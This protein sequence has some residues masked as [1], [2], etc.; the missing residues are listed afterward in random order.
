MP[1]IDVHTGE[2]LTI[3]FPPHY[4]RQADGTGKLSVDSTSPPPISPDGSESLAFS[5]RGRIPP[6]RKAWNFLPDLIAN[7]P[8]EDGD[9]GSPY[10]FETRK[11]L[12]PLHILQPD[13]V[14]FKVTGNV[15]EW[16]GWKMHAGESFPIFC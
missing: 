11:N 4:V 3:D 6:P 2:L 16:Q 5:N 1:V 12:K 9:G 14:S 10:D 7:P 8:T 13:G 15:I